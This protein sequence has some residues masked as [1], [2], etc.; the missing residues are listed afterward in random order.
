M[1]AKVLSI[2]NYTHM[3]VTAV[4]FGGTA[5][6][7]KLT[8]PSLSGSQVIPLFEALADDIIA[9]D[10]LV[11]DGDGEGFTNFQVTSF[12]VAPTILITS[13][14]DMSP[15]GTVPEARYRIGSWG[16]YRAV[17]KREVAPDEFQFD[18]YDFVYDFLNYKRQSL[19]PS[20]IVVLLPGYSNFDYSLEPAA[21]VPRWE[22]KSTVL[23]PADFAASSANGSLSMGIG[24]NL[25]DGYTADLCVH[26]NYISFGWNADFGNV[27]VGLFI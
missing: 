2:G 23:R 16:Y 1:S 18:P 12:R 21:A 4:N 5:G 24:I 13:A 7:G 14:F 9:D 20:E 8:Y 10:G 6:L 26:Y 27:N 15:F 11:E 22:D 25:N 17:E 3:T 19:N